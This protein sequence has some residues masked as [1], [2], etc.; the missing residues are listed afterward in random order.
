MKSRSDLKR[1]YKERKRPMGV[2]LVRNRRSGRFQVH[3]ALDLQAAMNRLRA[4]IT[5]ATNP[6]LELLR[7]WKAMGA[8]AFEVRVLDELKPRD[9]PGWDPREDLAELAAMWREKLAGEGGASY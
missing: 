7:D 6:N 5:P 4:E 9:V 1:E 2:F 8:E 3:A